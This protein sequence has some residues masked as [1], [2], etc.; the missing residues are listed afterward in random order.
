MPYL[1]PDSKPSAT[2]TVTFELPDSEEW[3]AVL[4]GAVLE[5]TR[6]ENWELFGSLTPENMAQ[7][8][9]DIYLNVTIT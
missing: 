4:L 3:L 8:F 7:D 1:T 6:V 9:D 5:L 2:I